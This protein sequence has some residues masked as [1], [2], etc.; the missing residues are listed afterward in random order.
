MRVL[1]SIVRGIRTWCGNRDTNSSDAG[2][3]RVLKLLTIAREN[4]GMADTTTT[5][6]CATCTSPIQNIIGFTKEEVQNILQRPNSVYMIVCI[7]CW[8]GYPASNFA[9]VVPKPVEE[10]NL[11]PSG[12]VVQPIRSQEEQQNSAS[13]STDV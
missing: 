4:I 3:R 7:E 8:L 10:T 13:E 12:L 5:H 11:I 2:G 1:V 9:L 6:E